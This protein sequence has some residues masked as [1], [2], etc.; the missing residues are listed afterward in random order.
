MMI[1][2]HVHIG[3]MLNFDMTEEM[4]IE[5]MK[6]YGIDYALV[7][8]IDSTELD[9]EQKMLPEEVQISQEKSL[10][11]V[12][13]F[14]RKYP[15][16][17]GVLVWIKPYSE[18]I[19][20]ELIRMIEENKDIIY[21]MKVHQY[22]SNTGLDHPRMLPYLKLAKRYG[23]PVMAHTDGDG[24]ASV[25]HVWKAAKENPEL[26]FIMA[27]MGL[28]TDHEEAIQL[29]GTLPNLYGDTA[30]VPLTS[31]MKAIECVGSKK[32]LFGSDMPIDGVDTYHHNPK[33]ELSIYQ[34]YLHDLETQIGKEA[35]ANLMYQNAIR[36]FHLPIEIK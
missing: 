35:Y 21:G 32:I 11:R 31:T 33:G 16:K 8:N 13:A 24:E 36:L 7:S 27:H 22:H 5:S 28:Q 6:K 10:E 23:F 9:F 4:V 18:K 25:W 14:A 3:N 26:N 1:D 19:S 29:L 2:S 15:D 17:I 34:S 12:L 20:D 30:W